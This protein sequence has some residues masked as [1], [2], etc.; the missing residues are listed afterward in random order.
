MSNT[1]ASSVSYLPTS[2]GRSVIFSCRKMES[3]KSLDKALISTDRNLRY[4]I[5]RC[6]ARGLLS[7]SVQCTV[8]SKMVRQCRMSDHDTIH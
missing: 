4:L 5:S 6:S 3:L 1:L 7:F 2:V 8:H